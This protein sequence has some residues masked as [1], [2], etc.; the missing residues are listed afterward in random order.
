[1]VKKGGEQANLGKQSH[2]HN[3]QGEGLKSITVSTLPC[4]K[5]GM[6]LTK[7]TTRLSPAFTNSKV[8]LQ[9]SPKLTDATRLVPE[10][11]AVKQ[12]ELMT[13]WRR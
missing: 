4:P 12:N 11:K 7:G 1:M 13:K 2:H 6:G 8:I 5:K 3:Q 10:V 9:S